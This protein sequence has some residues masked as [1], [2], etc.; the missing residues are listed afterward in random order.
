MTVSIPTAESAAA[1]RDIS[2]QPAMH[3]ARP[4]AVAIISALAVIVESIE[5]SFFLPPDS[6]VSLGPGHRQR[7]FRTAATIHLRLVLNRIK[8][9]L[10]VQFQ[11]QAVIHHAFLHVAARF[12]AQRQ[13][14][15]AGFQ[16]SALKGMSRR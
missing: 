6:I 1:D 3:S 13:H 4:N 15:A 12:L 7:S 11:S 10:S 5:L 14:I 8:V 2:A 9:T 16:P